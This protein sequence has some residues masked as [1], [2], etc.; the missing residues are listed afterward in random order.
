M[1][2][3]DMIIWELTDQGKD[4]SPTAATNAVDID[5][6]STNAA[7]DVI[8]KLVKN[9]G[10]KVD[11]SALDLIKKGFG[12]A[13]TKAVNMHTLQDKITL[14]DTITSTAPSFSPD[15]KLMTY[16]SLDKSIS[17]DPE[18][19]RSQH[20]DSKVIASISWDETI[21]VYNVETG[22]CLRV[23]GP[24]GGQ[25]WCGAFS[26]DS[27]YIAASGGG[28]KSTI[29]IYN[30]QTGEEVSRFEGFKHWICTIDWSPDGKLLAAGGGLG[31]LRVL[32]P[33]TGE[34][35]MRWSMAFENYMAGPFLEVFM[36]KFI[37]GGRKLMFRTTEGTTEIYNIILNSKQQ[38]TRGIEDT[39]PSTTRA[40]PI[41]S[42]DSSFIVCQD[43]DQAVR[44]WRLK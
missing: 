37:D 38:F 1:R 22:A 33:F 39:I 12:S 28:P 6:T 42:A 19:L 32:D 29:Y 3:G 36:I 5:I 7:D 24:F 11:E 23:W 10:W 15:G 40:W 9:H 2:E 13:V 14:K 21:R 41:C 8:S 17:D 20:P 44:F 16:I 30:M 4:A 18:D 31:E 26:P 43:Q 34:E 35:K 25:M 27:K